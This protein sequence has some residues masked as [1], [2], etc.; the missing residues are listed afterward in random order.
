MVKNI[1]YESNKYNFKILI[2][3]YSYSKNKFLNWLSVRSNMQMSK[4]V[5]TSWYFLV[6]FVGTHW[7]SLQ[8]WWQQA[9][10]PPQRLTRRHNGQKMV[11]VRFSSSL[12]DTEK[13]R[14][15]QLYSRTSSFR[16]LRSTTAKRQTDWCFSDSWSNFSRADP[17]GMI[18]FVQV[19]TQV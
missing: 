19:Y 18:I 1:Y 5:H 12:S 16:R 15:V 10:F 9:Q 2:L 7:H 11:S 4:K 17:W 6:T 8:L 3:V 14:G 13:L